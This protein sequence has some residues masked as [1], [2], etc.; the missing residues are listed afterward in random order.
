VV[1]PY[2][3]RMYDEM[4]ALQEGGTVD[5]DMGIQI[6]FLDG[7]EAFKTW[8]DSDSLYGSR[9]VVFCYITLYHSC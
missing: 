7:E 6:L 3:T 5:M 1:D 2:I 9:Y 4:A 8:T